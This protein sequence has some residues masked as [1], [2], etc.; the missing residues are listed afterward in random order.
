MGVFH[1]K[2]VELFEEEDVQLFA[3][4]LKT[5]PKRALLKA[6]CRIVHD[7]EG[8][9]STASMLLRKAYPTA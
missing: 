9:N 8:T 7:C 3:S 4:H 6:L 5:M 2:M 1:P